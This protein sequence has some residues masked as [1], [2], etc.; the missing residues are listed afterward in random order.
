[1]SIA[2][3][4]QAHSNIK[5]VLI[6][7]KVRYAD[8][9]DAVFVSSYSDVVF[10]NNNFF[11]AV[12]DIQKRSLFLLFFLCRRHRER[13]LDIILFAPLC[14]DEIHLETLFDRLSVLVL[15]VNIDKPEVH[16]VAAISQF[17]VDDVLHQVILFR[18]PKIEPCIPQPYVFKIVLQ[19]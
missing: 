18:L 1:M 14:R 19:K 3:T 2:N 7:Q 5:A 15:A 4:N 16:I 6:E 8:G 11:E 17:V 13:R 12:A 9:D 10:D